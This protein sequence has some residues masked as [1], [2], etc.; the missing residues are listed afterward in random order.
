MEL[1]FE[2]I[3][4]EDVPELTRV[5]T[6]AFDDDG[7]FFRQWLFP[8]EESQESLRPEARHGR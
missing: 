2:G 7:G 8:Y 5:M 1:I 6:R 4:E 3:T